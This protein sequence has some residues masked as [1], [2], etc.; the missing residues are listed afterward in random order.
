MFAYVHIFCREALSSE[1]MK[2]Q[3]P[4]TMPLWNLVL[5]ALAPT[6]KY[7]QMRSSILT[8]TSR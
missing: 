4:E 7:F 8:Q 1:M 2:E 6:A 3:S 5:R